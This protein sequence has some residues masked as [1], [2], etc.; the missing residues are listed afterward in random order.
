MRWLDRAAFG[1]AATTLLALAAALAGWSALDAWRI[2][3]P[4]AAPAAPPPR[5]EMRN[6]TSGPDSSLTA[7]LVRAVDRDPF[8]PDRRPASLGYRLPGEP[9]PPKPPNIS[10]WRLVG[11]AARAGG[12][13]IAAIAIGSESRIYHVGDSVAELRLV[14]VE[15]GLAEL[16]WGD[17]TL[18]LTSGTTSGRAP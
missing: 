2:R 12:D 13:G 5:L 9:P 3:A 6:V 17:T 10:G 18:V 4:D 15:S 16:S 1:G 11:T 14:R 7:S 8:R